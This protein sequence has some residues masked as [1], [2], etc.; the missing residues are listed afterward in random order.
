MFLLL[1]SDE[2]CR[3]ATRRVINAPFGRGLKEVDCC[4][5]GVWIVAQ[6][7]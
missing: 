3:N 5:T 1:L 2:T 4:P 6:T 7:E